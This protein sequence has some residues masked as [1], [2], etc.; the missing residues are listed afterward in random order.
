[1]VIVGVILLLHTENY[2]NLTLY[3]SKIGDTSY[4][5]VKLFELRN[6]I[7]QLPQ[8]CFNIKVDFHYCEFLG[9]CGVAFLGGLFR[10]ITARGGYVT[11]D[12]NTLSP[13]IHTNLAQNGFL[14]DFGYDCKPWNGNSIPYR[15]DFQQ[16]L[17]SITNYLKY[18][19]L[20][21]GW[22]NISPRLQN[23]ITGQVLEIYLNAFEHS[24]S[25]VGVFTCGQHYP[26]RGILHLTVIDF[27]IGIPT[28]VRSLP[29]NLN[30]TTTEALQWAFAPGNSTKQGSVACGAGLDLLQDFITKNHGELT[31]F[32]NDGYV[33]VS[34]NIMYENRCT[35]FRGTLIDIALKCD[36]SYYCLASEAHQFK[37]RLF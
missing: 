27:G 3:I 4:D 22:V 26:N 19:W 9:H 33:N 29:Q 31:I 6:T 7:E 8:T 14:L 23:V 1:M 25:D 15:N 32:S 30:K 35:S 36:E 18:N 34:D 24:Q 2:P 5:F 13:K 20:G 12:W 16:D 37:K 21:K 10:L 11:L 17:T 28:S